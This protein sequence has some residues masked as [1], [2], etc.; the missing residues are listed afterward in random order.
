MKL[1][2]YIHIGRL[3]DFRKGRP[4]NA[5]IG[6]ASQYDVKVLVDLRKFFVFIPQGQN[7]LIV[8][9]KKNIIDWLGLRKLFKYKSD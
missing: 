3:E 1:E 5:K 6:F 9:R 7:G 4:V 2:V 8:L